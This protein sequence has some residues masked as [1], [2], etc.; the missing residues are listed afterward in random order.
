V[1]KEIKVVPEIHFV[2]LLKFEAPAR[3]ILVE[4]TL[5][6]NLWCF[7]ARVV[8]FHTYPLQCKAIHYSLRVLPKLEKS[9]ETWSNTLHMANY[10]P[11]SRA[12]TPLR[13]IRHLQEWSTSSEGGAV[14]HSEIK[15]CQKKFKKHI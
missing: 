12:C 3:T 13:N 14:S 6:L 7:G 11:I 15:C 10:R 5:A 4:S 8:Y 2:V 1:K 9:Q